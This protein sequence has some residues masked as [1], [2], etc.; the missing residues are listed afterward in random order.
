MEKLKTLRAAIEAAVPDLGRN[1]DK[2]VLLVQKGDV[3]STSRVHAS[4]EYRYQAQILVKDYADHVDKLVVAIILWC[5]THQAEVFDAWRHTREGISFEA[6]MLNETDVDV[7]IT[8]PL[9]ERVLVRTLDTGEVT[10]E[11]VGE[12]PAPDPLGTPLA[13]HFTG[14]VIRTEGQPD[15]PA[16]GPA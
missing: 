1:P 10:I 13:P 9:T 3:A 5:Q 11:H 2:L 6:E 7:L 16:T 14:M 8:L 12:P 4:F 15:E